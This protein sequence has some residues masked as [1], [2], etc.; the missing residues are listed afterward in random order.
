MTPRRTTISIVTLH[1]LSRLYSPA[2]TTIFAS[3]GFLE[4]VFRKVR[5]AFVDVED[6]KSPICGGLP[7]PLH[8]QYLLYVYTCNDKPDGSFLLDGLNPHSICPTT[9]GTI[10]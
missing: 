9:S 2:F 6:A 4:E 7:N 3:D 1:C 5:N 10:I 8:R